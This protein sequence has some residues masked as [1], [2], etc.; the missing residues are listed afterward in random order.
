MAFTEE[1]LT[2]NT[3][4]EA[5]PLLRRARGILKPPG[6]WTQ[7]AW[8]TNREGEPVSPVADVSHSYCIGG[9]VLRAEFELHGGAVRI[10]ETP[11]E[12]DRVIGPKRVESA[13]R[14]LA[15]PMVW[16][17]LCLYRDEIEA[18]G[19]DPSQVENRCQDETAIASIIN[20]QARVTQRH[21]L[22]ILALAIELVEQELRKRRRQA[23]ERGRS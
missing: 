17:Y 10:V 2:T 9:A 23:R 6:R 4:R 18:Q 21:V 8:A 16:L 7:F 11:G 20:D 15:L 1:T 13:L 5:L 22:I 14:L 3:L 19:Q 12:P